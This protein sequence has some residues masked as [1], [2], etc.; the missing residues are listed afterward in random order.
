M[1]GYQKIILIFFISAASVI[2]TFISP[3]L[4]SLKKLFLCTSSSLSPIMT[5]YLIGYLLGQIS[6]G[7]LSKKCGGITSIRYGFIIATIALFLQ[8]ISI[9]FPTYSIFLAGRFLTAFGLA[10]GLVCG[11]S[12]IKDNI[13][14]QEEK[15]YLSIIA[16]AFTGAIYGSI[17]ISG[18]L[19]TYLELNSIFKIQALYPIVLLPL[20]YLIPDTKKVILTSRKRDYDQLFNYKLISYSLSLSIT[21]IIGYCYSFYTPLIF[22]DSFGLT[23]EAYSHYNLINMFGIF[24]GSIIYVKL[25][26]ILKE[27]DI[28]LAGLVGFIFSGLLLII[29]SL[30][31]IHFYQF[32]SLFFIINILSG[33]MYPAA[34]YQA[35]SCGVCKT[36]T[37]TTMNMIKIG[38]PSVALSF[39]F[40]IN[41]QDMMNLSITILFFASFYLLFATVSHFIKVKHS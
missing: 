27:D 35:L 19:M 7:A 5:I 10:S 3:E 32:I 6:F 23:S 30:Q 28:V 41:A 36:T 40:F 20:T 8:H 11:F 25:C 12:I 1:V 18:S 15:G 13:L 33:I 4:S 21:T 34:T 26:T 31:K 17:V 9:K 24:I 39:S 37:S 14:S 22:I 2:A 16:I 29:L 38:M